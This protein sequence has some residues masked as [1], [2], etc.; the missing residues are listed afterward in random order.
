MTADSIPFVDLAAQQ[1]RIRP[2][3]DRAIARV[4]DH[5]RYVMGPEV[6]ELECELAGYAGVRDAVGCAS[7]TDALLLA[8]MLHEI[9]P[10]DAV[11]VP[12]FTFAASA[13]VVALAGATPVFVDVEA[14]SYNLDPDLI[15]PAVALARNRSLI[16]KA[17][18]PVDLFGRPADYARILPLADTH[19]LTVIADAAQSFG[20]ELGGT[21]AGALAPVTATSFFPAK[22]LGAYGD[23]GAVFTNAPADGELLRS[24]RVHG[25]GSGGKYDNDRVGLNARL[26]TIQAAV[27][28]EKLKIFP[29]ELA[30]RRALARRYDEGLSD[31]VATPGL[32]AGVESAW[33]QYTIRHPRRDRLAAALQQRGVPTRVYYPTPLH[34]LPAYRGALAPEGG[35]PVTDRLADEVLSLPMTPYLS[36]TQTAY[37]VDAVRAAAAEVGAGA[38]AE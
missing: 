18:M 35:L 17:I 30:A 33:A 15:A 9:G 16:P 26:D 19:G 29:D 11:L 38:A 1:A 13:E 27:L 10:G 3:I 8:L 32:P 6:G 22:P 37:V 21:R 36:E 7:G 4:L 24:L 14:D 31:L 5:G 25:Q 12:S 20:A 34:R 28:L 2:Q 23:G